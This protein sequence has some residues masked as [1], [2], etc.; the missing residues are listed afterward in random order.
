MRVNRTAMTRRRALLLGL[1]ALGAAAG[2]ARLRARVFS[3]G[4]LKFGGEVLLWPQ[5]TRL[6]ENLWARLAQP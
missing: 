1:G 3:A 2:P 6:L 4:V 5:S